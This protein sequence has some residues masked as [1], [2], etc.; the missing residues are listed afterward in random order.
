MKK[1]G[2]TL[3][4]AFA[5]LSLANGSS[6]QEPQALP[7]AD[8][9]YKTDILLVVAHPDDEGAATPYL[10]RALDEH[11]RIGVVFGTRGSSGAN[12]AGAEQAAAL[13]AVREIEARN[14]LT[15]L[16]ITN[17]WF[18]GGKDTASQNVLQSLANWDH[19]ESLEQLVRLVRLTRPEVILTF[20]PG[21]FIGEDHGD[22]QASGLLATEAFDSAGDPVAFPEQVAG[23]S[24]RL[25]PYLEN[26]RP[27]QPK[28]IYYFADA[29]R[30]D[31]FKGKGPDYSVTGISKSGKLPYWRMGLDSFRSHQTQ[32]KS[33]LDKVAQ[34]DEA[35]IEKMA[36]SDSF[37][38]ES[39]HFVLGKS[40]VGG[41]VAGDIFEGITP[42]AIPFSRPDISPEPARPELS[43]ELGGPYSFYA[44]FRRAHGL[45]HLPHP[46]PP[47]IAMQG[48]TSMVI[49]L[50]VRNRTA[51]TQQISLAAM[52]PAGWTVQNGTGKFTVA[53]KQV[54]AARI[55][56]MLPAIP[57][58]ETKK[59]EP[60][61]VIVRAESSGQSIGE[62]KLRVEVR[63]RALP[64]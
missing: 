58:N 27:W 41:S 29:D 60:Q 21:T 13:G 54:A 40:L 37:W 30:E 45:T 5:L 55:E 36:T 63:K 25:E 14:A 44:E 22:H 12:E 39:L 10:A 52:L 28:K 2:F 38:T 26:L 7:A 33:F 35:Q 53:A 32:A 9:R 47:E 48:H 11:K 3:S 49:P 23:P 50:W 8:E 62:I 31:I 61:D 4:F 56:I 51:K 64:Q 57:E 34:M 17:V 16:G 20:L 19:G 42:G 43:V 59:P 6:G 24:K 18:L 1:S 46:E 15:T